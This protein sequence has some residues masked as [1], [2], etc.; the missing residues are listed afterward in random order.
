MTSC[1]I[2][3]DERMNDSLQQVHSSPCSQMTG[4]RGLVCSACATRPTIAGGRPS[5]QAVIVQKRM[6]SRRLTPWRCRSSYVD[7]RSGWRL[8]TISG[9]FCRSLGKSPSS[10]TG[11]D[12]APIHINALAPGTTVVAEAVRGRARCADRPCA[13]MNRYQSALG[14]E[15][16]IPPRSRICCPQA[17]CTGA[18]P[19]SC[20]GPR[21]CPCPCACPPSLP[22]P[23]ESMKGRGKGEGGRRTG[24]GMHNGKGKEAAPRTGWRAPRQSGWN[25]RDSTRAELGRWPR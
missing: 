23:S 6:N 22:F 4:M 25:A 5:A 16:G 24:M 13:L 1:A 12:T 8:A 21:P 11:G 10:E 19:C 7:I 2:G 9:P 18:C 3:C 20:A 15:S 17:P 14:A